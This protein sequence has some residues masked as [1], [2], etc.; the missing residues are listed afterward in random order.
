MTRVM[1]TGSSGFIGKA[2]CKHL[3]GKGFDVNNA[4]RSASQQDDTENIVKTVIGEINANT[5]WQAVLVQIDVVIHLAARVHITNEGAADSLAEFRKVNVD[6][7]LNLARQ[8]V[9]S[10]VRRFIFISSIKV[11]GE[12]TTPGVP[13]SAD[14][15]PAPADAYG[16]S[17]LEAED[18]LRIL[19]AET[20]L[21]VVIIRPPIVYGPGVKANFN[22]MLC[23]IN[24]AI[25]L[26]FGAIHNR[27][28]LLALDN[29][30]DLISV[31]VDHPVAVNQ[32]FLASD[33]EDLSTTDLLRRMA[34]ALGKKCYLLPI[35]LVIIKL[36]AE[37]VGRKIL[38]QKLCDSL[39]VDM[40]KTCEL[41]SW[42]PPVSVDEA[43]RRT[44]KH[45]KAIHKC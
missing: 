2:L 38:V 15:Q 26:P 25:P 30:V 20:G 37:L 8:A 12:T 3:A 13:F 6:G 31:C 44:A 19:A 35:P 16:I 7:T 42:V 27:R 45:Y 14:D 10:G 4:L 28:S 9:N 29:L 41:L 24:R 21:E 32:T 40:S 5:D 39:Q 22:A 34:N 43:L 36:V 11:N 23:C 33:G 1:V 18:A 17:K